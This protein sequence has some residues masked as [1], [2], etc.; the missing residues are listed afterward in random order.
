MAPLKKD[1]EK[2]IDEMMKIA[3]RVLEGLHK[4]DRTILEHSNV[5]DFIEK[6]FGVIGKQYYDKIK[7]S[8]L[9]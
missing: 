4:K 5:T 3:S 2:E 1:A 9:K 8:Y 7:E 6:N